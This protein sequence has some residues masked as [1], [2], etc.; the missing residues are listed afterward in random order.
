MRRSVPVMRDA[1]TALLVVVG[2]ATAAGVADAGSWAAS[3]PPSFVVTQVRASLVRAKDPRPTSASFVL[4]HRQAA[5]KVLSGA[6]VNSNQ[7]VYVVVVKGSFTVVRPGPNASG[8]M[9]VTVLNYAF[10]ARTGRETNGGF[11]RVL[12]DLAK[13]GRVHDLLPYLRHS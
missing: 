8:F 10:D 12:P 5:N 7:P 13:L 6:S 2:G 9:H 1:L 4:T 11:G 3:V